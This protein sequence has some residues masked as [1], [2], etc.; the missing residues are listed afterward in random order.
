[1]LAYLRL[2]ATTLA[3]VAAAFATTLGALFFGAA[4]A[5]TLFLAAGLAAGMAA[6]LAA[7]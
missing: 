2:A 7:G 5:L 3:F 6:G 4:A 1:M